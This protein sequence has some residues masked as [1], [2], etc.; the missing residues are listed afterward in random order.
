MK[1]CR[2]GA[3]YMALAAAFCF[4]CIGVV[5]KAEIRPS[6][7]EQVGENTVLEKIPQVAPGMV[8]QEMADAGAHNPA[9]TLTLSLPQFVEL[10]VKRNENIMVQEAEWAISKAKVKSAR[11][12]FEPEL[13]GSYLHE[14]SSQRNSIE[15]IV[16]RQYKSEYETRNNNYN[17]AVEEVIPTGAK[18]SLGYSL[19]EMSNSLTRDLA[20][21]D[22]EYR[23]IVN[24]SFTQPLLKNAGL[25][26][27]MANIRVVEADA[28]LAF[29]TYRQ[30]IM[31]VVVN[32]VVKFWDFYL[33]QEKAALR[34]E[35]LLAARQ[36]LTDVRERFRTGKTAETEVL[37]AEA[38]V[39]LRKSLESESRQEVAA[40][41]ND[42]RTIS[43]FSTTVDDRK[44]VADEQLV[45]EEL[46]ID[47]QDTMVRVFKLR[48]E[49]LSALRKVER[50]NIR[51]AY[52]KNQRWPQLD[53]K[54]SY[55]M[56]GLDFRDRGAWNELKSRDYE[57]WTAG[58]E[59]RVPLMGGLKSGGEL[60]AVK[61]KGKQALLE[62][63]AVEVALTNSADTAVRN[64][65]SATEQVRYSSQVVAIN[66]RLLD[67]EKARL[68]AG[69]SNT[70]LVL[71]KEENFREAKESELASLVNYKKA[72]LGLEVTQG[73]LLTRYG[74]EKMEVEL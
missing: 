32:A 38:G 23:M 14:D 21:K 69:K 71:D 18:L 1:N 67:A 66:R 27:T 29:Q 59:F 68:I 61:Q 50:E 65:Y 45:L 25:K 57:S 37:E 13:V 12:I 19:Q 28:D 34:S 36:V 56:N 73:T 31:R 30:E 5:V 51:L 10:V 46:E 4:S 11:S 2:F 74:I 17:V 24:A 40:S 62:L 39:I 53:L 63:K 7:Q 15:E 60:D 54:G 47:L 35:S 20:R 6:G 8:A 48:P 55:G 16:S 9:E 3:R 26:T 52:A 70:R 44:I 41:M 49:Y 33:A 22:N 72:I 64:V 58:L 42:L 43:S